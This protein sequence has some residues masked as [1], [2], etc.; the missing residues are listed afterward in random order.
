MD[1]TNPQN[2]TGGGQQ[3]GNPQTIGGLELQ[4]PASKLQGV[5]NLSGLL[6]NQPSS[7]HQLRVG[8]LSNGTTLG[9]T[10]TQLTAPLPSTS[11]QNLLWAYLGLGLVVIIL[12]S[13]MIFGLF[14][15]PA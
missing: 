2:I 6:N 9:A 14:R 5:D 8:T 1:S 7:Q 12:T 11:Q 13:L 4:Q 10:T 15:E 3:T